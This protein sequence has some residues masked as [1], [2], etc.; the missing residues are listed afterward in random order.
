MER[1]KS[2]DCF[3]HARNDDETEYLLSAFADLCFK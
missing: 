1:E 3:A 2:L